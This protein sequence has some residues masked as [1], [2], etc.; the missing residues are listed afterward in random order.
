[1]PGLKKRVIDEVRVLVKRRGWERVGRRVVGKGKGKMPAQEVGEEGGYTA[2]PE[3]QKDKSSEREAEDTSG[4]GRIAGVE[5]FGS[6]VG[7][8]LVAGM[9]VRG[10]IE[11]EREK[12]LAAVAAGGTGFPLDV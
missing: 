4:R 10:T 12:F 2:S 6:W 1:M 9:K 3:E 8:S 11:V 5:S 7:A